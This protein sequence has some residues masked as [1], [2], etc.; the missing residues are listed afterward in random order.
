MAMTTIT[1][2][3][4]R[5]TGRRRGCAG[6]AGDAGGLPAVSTW[7]TAASALMSFPRPHASS[8][9]PDDSRSLPQPRAIRGVA[10]VEPRADAR[11]PPVL[12]EHLLPERIDG[13]ALDQVHGAPTKAATRD[14]R[15]EHTRAPPREIHEQVDLF[16]AHLVVVPQRCVRYV[17]ELAE[18]A[19]VAFAERRFRLE[20]ARILGDDVA[21]API[22]HLVELGA[23]GLE[24]I[25][26]GV[27]QGPDPG[28]ARAQRLDARRALA[29][30]EVVLRCD[31][32]VLHAAVA[33][34]D[35]VLAERERHLLGRERAAIEEDRVSRPRRERDERVHDADLH[36]DDLVLRFLADP[37][38]PLV[39]H[40]EAAERPGG[41]PGRHL[42]R[43]GRGEA[44]PLRQVPAE[45]DV[46]PRKRDPG[47]AQRP[48]DAADVVAPAM[49]RVGADRLADGKGNA[50]A[51]VRGVHAN[52]AAGAG[53]R[54]HLDS[55][56]DR[57]RQDEPLVVVGVLA[58][59]VHAARRECGDDC[60]AGAERGLEH[61]RHG[62]APRH[63]PPAFSAV[64]TAATLGGP[65]RRSSA[66]LSSGSLS[67]MKVPAPDS[68]PAR[69]LSRFAARW[70][71]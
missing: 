64:L 24:L 52:L 9:R 6:D 5:S 56:L 31:Q 25:E 39:V 28:V 23:A 61:V 54:R 16:A 29:T 11:P 40:R 55:G 42:E 35:Q 49:V 27:A 13:A 22:H 21:A 46:H 59:E 4:T 36:P 14:A 10:Q 71:V 7:T 44:C 30:P 3:R 15:T 12:A 32:R 67:L 50:L 1:K 43:G 26:R 8:A 69:N 66:A 63:I 2:P 57:H 60:A 53:A 20:D 68:T 33:D 34:R 19:K 58:D 47:A 62:S 45:R 38:W 51:Q 17:H 37:R 18:A 41:D 70:G 48:E 65:T